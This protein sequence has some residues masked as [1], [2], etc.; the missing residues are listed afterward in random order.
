[1]QIS[2]HILTFCHRTHIVKCWI[3]V[4]QSLSHV[5][6]FCNLMDYSLPGSSV[7]GTFLGQNTG[8]GCHF[9]LQGI[10]S[11][12]GLNLCLL[13]WQELPAT[14]PPRNPDCPPLKAKAILL[15]LTSMENASFLILSTIR[16]HLS[17]FT[18]LLMMVLLEMLDTIS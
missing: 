12:Q 3:V 18:V 9:L 13:H 1:M 7:H 6:L 5:W 14:E 17:C 4:L 8:M 16:D 11:T 2:V 10:F 15:P